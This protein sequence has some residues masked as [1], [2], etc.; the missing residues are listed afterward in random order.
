MEFLAEGGIA[1]VGLGLIFVALL[2]MNS[3]YFRWKTK[4]V[5][6]I[7]VVLALVVYFAAGFV[8]ESIPD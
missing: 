1:V 4:R 3:A 7:V 8:L 6:A 2:W 5:V